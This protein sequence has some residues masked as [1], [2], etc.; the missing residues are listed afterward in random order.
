MFRNDLGD[1][2]LFGGHTTA[3]GPRPS[4]CPA[5]E[6]LEE[7]LV[8]DGSPSDNSGTIFQLNQLT[9]LATALTVSL[10]KSVKHSLDSDAAMAHAERQGR[11]FEKVEGLL[12]Q[13]WVYLLDAANPDD[14]YSFLNIVNGQVADDQLTVAARQT[15]AALNQLSNTIYLAEHHHRP[16]AATQA[17]NVNVSALATQVVSGLL[18]FEFV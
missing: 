13:Q 4:F 7:R 16:P 12:A 1:V 6:V 11:A 10:E 18:S 9:Q 15:Q 3:A 17:A 8:L 14:P 5:V 2:R